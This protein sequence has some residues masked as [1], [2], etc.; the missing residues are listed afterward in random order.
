MYRCEYCLSE[1][2]LTKEKLFNHVE[3]CKNNDKNIN[4]VLPQEG[5]NILKFKNHNHKFM[6]PFYITADF[7]S[8]LIPV[9][10]VNGDTTKYQ[11]HVP[12]SYGIKF[13][14][15][16]DEFSKPVKI[17]NNEAPELVC[18]NFIEDIEKY[19]YIDINPLYCPDNK[20]VIGKFKNETS[21]KQIVEFVGLRPKLYSFKTDDGNEK[22]TCKGVKRNVVKNKIT[23]DDY[24]TTL[25]TH[26]NKEI[27]QNT[28]RSY[29][30]E[31]FSITQNKIALSCFDDKIFINDDNI[32]CISFCH[33]L[34][35]DK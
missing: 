25:Y 8:T 32:S 18:K 27:S 4:E 29:S 19:S 5:K 30:H 26:K 10:E 14:C 6:H 2:F 21:E 31:I 1:R 11:K 20:K 7:E 35:S 22:K 28:I 24:T 9:N 34:I 23:L 13:N 17:Y 15:I 16:H 12:N 33:K 3:K